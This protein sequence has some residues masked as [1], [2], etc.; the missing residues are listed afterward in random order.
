M[1]QAHP[2]RPRRP[3]RWTRVLRFQHVT[4]EHSHRAG[5]ATLTLVCL[6]QFM[7]ILDVSIVNVALPSIRDDLHFSE[8]DLQW[9]V[10]AYTITFAGFLLLGGRFCDVLGRR[11]G[12]IGG[13]APFPGGAPVG[14]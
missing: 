7:V 13:A 3:A 5:W 12:V 10:N 14:G 4:D 8:V 6:A 9:I 11:R 1:Q 2:G